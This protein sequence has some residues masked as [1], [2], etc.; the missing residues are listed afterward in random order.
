MSEICS[1]Y[2]KNKQRV[3]LVTSSPSFIHGLQSNK[4][5]VMTRKPSR[6]QNTAK[7]GALAGSTSDARLTAS[8]EYIGD[9]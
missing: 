1:I 4:K 3:S 8:F 9:K 7:T 5:W 6:L 2:K